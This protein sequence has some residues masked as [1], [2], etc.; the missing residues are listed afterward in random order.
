MVSG[1]TVRVQRADRRVDMF[2]LRFGVVIG[3][4]LRCFL[5]TTGK[6]CDVRSGM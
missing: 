4:N 6:T 2:G 5:V 3:A 1:R